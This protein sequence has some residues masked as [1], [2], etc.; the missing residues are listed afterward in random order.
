MGHYTKSIT[1][2]TITDLEKKIQSISERI[3]ILFCGNWIQKYLLLKILKHKL[4]KLQQKQFYSVD[5]YL[6]NT[7]KTYL[8]IAQES[9]KILEEDEIEFIVYEE[10]YSV[11]GNYTEKVEGTIHSNGCSY[12]YSKERN[13]PSLPFDSWR[14]TAEMTG[15]IDYWGRV[16]LKTSKTKYAMFKNVPNRFKGYVSTEGEIK[17]L[18]IKNDYD[19]ISSGRATMGKLIAKHFAGDENKKAEFFANKEI[20]AK[21]ILEYRKTLIV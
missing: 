15:N 9:L 10:Q 12:S 7:D 14:Y 18:N 21:M 6:I 3:D 19:F 2:S 11:I 1:L 8:N 20:L 17:L 5:E 16:Y 4:E 13:F